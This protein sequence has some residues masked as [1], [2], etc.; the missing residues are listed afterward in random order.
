MQEVLHGFHTRIEQQLECNGFKL[1]PQRY[2]VEHWKFGNYVALLPEH[3]KWIR[4]VLARHPHP[5][6]RKP[7]RTCHYDLGFS[8][9]TFDSVAAFLRLDIHSSGGQP[10]A[11]LVERFL[12]FDVWMIVH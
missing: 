3:N 8:I 4:R 12:R 6:Q 2:V 11:A 9:R 10:M 5:Q 1:W 7:G